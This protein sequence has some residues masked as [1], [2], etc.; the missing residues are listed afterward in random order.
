MRIGDF[1]YDLPKDM[2]A[3]HPCIQRDGCRLLVVNRAGSLIEHRAFSDIVEYVRPGDLLVLNDTKVVRCRLRGVRAS[4]GKVEAFLLK[5]LSAGVF[6]ALLKPAR[7]KLNERISF[8]GGR[9]SGRITGKKEVTFDVANPRIVYGAG[10]IPLPPY[11]RRPQTESDAEYY[12]TVYAQKDGAV[13][14]P[15]A[16]LHFTRDLLRELERAG[17]SIAYVTLHVGLG[18]FKPVTSGDIRAHTMEAEYFNVPDGTG[19]MIRA[20]RSAGRRIIAV[21]TTSVRAL[22]TYAA[23]TSEGSTDIFIYPGCEFKLV[24]GL[25]TNFHLPRTT[26]LMLTYAF[27]GMELIRK[28]YAEAIRQKYRFYSYG[29]AMLIL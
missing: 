3:Q 29:D 26:L 18:T 23:G 24:D 12:Q 20:A 22:E 4:G 6:E 19:A 28:A 27:G 15:T 10:E 5:Q 13:A 17:V 9:L 7:L 1:D 2:I 25:L 14:A 8:A 16:G 11:I 21:G